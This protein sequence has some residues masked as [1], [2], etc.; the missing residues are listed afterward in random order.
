MTKYTLKAGDLLMYEG[1]AGVIT[2]VTP[3]YVGYYTCWGGGP[4]DFFVEKK[5][6]IYKEIDAGRCGHQLDG[7]STK[8][9]RSR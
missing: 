7:G 3:K 8:W 6:V 4:G 1:R 5:E 9:R 2:K